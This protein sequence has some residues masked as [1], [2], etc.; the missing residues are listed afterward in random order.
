MLFRS[1]AT[2]SAAARDFSS[3]NRV[4]RSSA[5]HHTPTARMA[6]PKMDVDVPSPPKTKRKATKGASDSDDEA[7][8]DVE[9]SSLAR[10]CSPRTLPTR[11]NAR[12]DA[13]RRLHLL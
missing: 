7:G 6:P 9:V 8:S 10:P 5:S 13:R 11:L 1:E 3:E 12:A 4:L 2:S